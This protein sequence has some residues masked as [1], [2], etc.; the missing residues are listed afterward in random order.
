MPRLTWS[1]ALLFASFAFAA[2]AE[3]YPTEL[4]LDHP[5]QRRLVSK[6]GKSLEA[7]QKAC[8]VSL[9]NASPATEARNISEHILRLE[10]EVVIE[11]DAD[12][13]NVAVGNEHKTLPVTYRCEYRDG[14]MTLGI[15][16]RGMVGDWSVFRG[17][18]LSAADLGAPWPN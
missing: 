18:A 9:L 13:Q 14:L 12:L 15:W 17:A 3:G 4:K 10:D 6:P 5:D 16:T 8:P 7:M 11:V 1:A 2:H